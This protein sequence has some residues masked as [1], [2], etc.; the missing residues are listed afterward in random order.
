MVGTFHFDRYFHHYKKISLS[1][2]TIMYKKK[3]TYTKSIL[4]SGTQLFLCMLEQVNKVLQ[5]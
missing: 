3:Y 5:S 1:Y 4:T 2:E